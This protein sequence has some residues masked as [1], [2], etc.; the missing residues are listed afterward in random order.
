MRLRR[1]INRASTKRFRDWNAHEPRLDQSPGLITTLMSAG[2][3]F[4]NLRIVR[5]QKEKPSAKIGGFRVRS[6]RG[7]GIA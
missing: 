4:E 2:H 6:M 1:R 5:A 3:R 7:M